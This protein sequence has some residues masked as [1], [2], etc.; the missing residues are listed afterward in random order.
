ML[1]KDEYKQDNRGIQEKKLFDDQKESQE[2]WMLPEG[3]LLIGESEA[4]PWY[5]RFDFDRFHSECLYVLKIQGLTVPKA[6]VLKPWFKHIVGMRMFI[7]YHGQDNFL[8]FL[9][10]FS[11]HLW[12]IVDK[13]GIPTGKN[14]IVIDDIYRYCFGR[15]IGKVLN[16][17]QKQR[18][19]DFIKCCICG[20]TRHRRTPYCP[21]CGNE[22][23]FE[24]VSRQIEY[25]GQGEHLNFE[26]RRL[27]KIMIEEMINGYS[28]TK[29]RIAELHINKLYFKMRGKLIKTI[30]T[31]MISEK[32][33]IS[34]QMIRRHIREINE[35]W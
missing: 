26:D 32:I 29:S 6:F 23:D 18:D 11:S 8:A 28:K 25:I 1:D 9:D 10:E 4:I 33:D 31:K 27:L 2:K 15:S 17:I 12:R 5:R 14:G 24:Y 16:V 35:D 3:K 13:N 21:N 19:E 7:G 34:E 20:T 30:E 22:Y